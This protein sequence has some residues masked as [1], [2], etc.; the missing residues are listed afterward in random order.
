MRVRMHE[1]NRKIE[2]LVELEMVPHLGNGIAIIDR[3]ALAGPNVLYID[4]M[5]VH[6]CMGY[7]GALPT[8]SGRTVVVR[9]ARDS[10]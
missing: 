6:M 8:N 2:D 7:R 10:S 5:G 1:K 4:D 9:T 3:L